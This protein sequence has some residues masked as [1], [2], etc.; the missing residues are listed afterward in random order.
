MMK[1]RRWHKAQEYERSYWIKTAEKIVDGS[2]GQLGWYEWKF[3]EMEK[4]LLLHIPIERY[5]LLKILEIGCGPVGIVS[6]INR[7]SRYGL[8]PLEEFYKSNITLTKLRD[9]RVQYLVGTGEQIPFE[10]D[11]FDLVISDNVLDHV[12]NTNVVM[13]EIIRV[14]KTGGFLYLIVNLRTRSGTQ[15]HK[16]LS[17]LLI[18]KGHPQSFDV[19]SIRNLI[20]RFHLSIVSESISDYRDARLRDMRSLSI[21]DNIKGYTGLSEFLYHAVCQK[22]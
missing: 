6:Y 11:F 5:N 15:F 4:R 16:I 22:F 8:D 10:E 19:L 18:D 14:L 1:T 2:T 3:S 21:K 20:G 12:C 17:R 13:E 7:G 9:P